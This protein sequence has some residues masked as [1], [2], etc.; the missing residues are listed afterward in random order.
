MRSRGVDVLGPSS[1]LE[2]LAVGDHLAPLMGLPS[3]CGVAIESPR[4]L[5]GP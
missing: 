1:D 3:G 2:Y 5:G 4:A